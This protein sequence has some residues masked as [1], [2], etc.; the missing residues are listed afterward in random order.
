VQGKIAMTIPFGTKAETLERLAPLLTTAC[1]LPQYRFRHRDWSRQR[2]L[3]LAGL[4]SGGWLDRPVI[5]RSSALQ[6][7][8]GSGSLAGQLVSVADVQGEGAV[9]AAVDRVFSSYGV[10]AEDDQV[11]LQPLLS[12]PS[13]SGVAFGLE[14]NT[15]GPYLVINYDEGAQAGA[16][17]GGFSDADRTFYWFKGAA[18]PSSPPLAAVARL[19]RELEWLLGDEALDVEFAWKDEKLYLFQIRRLATLKGFGASRAEVAGLLQVV[20]NQVGRQAGERPRVL[21]SGVAWGIMPDWNPAEMIGIRPR[22]LAASLYRECLTDETWAR[23]RKRYAYRDLRGVPL[24]ECLGGQPFIDIRASFTSFVPTSLP[25]GLAEKLV[26]YYLEGLRSR[27]EL[28]DKVETELVLHCYTFDLPERLRDLAGAGFHEGERGQLTA[29]LRELTV[30]VMDAERGPWA[31]DRRKIDRFATWLDRHCSPES[32][33]AGDLLAFLRTCTERAAAPF[34]GLARAGFMATCLLRSL[35]RIGLWTPEEEERFLRGRRTVVSRMRE[36]RRHL[37]AAAFLSRYGHLRP[38]TYDILTPRYDEAPERYFL[39][40]SVEEAEEHA[41]FCLTLGQRGDL[42]ALLAAHKL[43][44]DPDAFLRFVGEAIE[45]R[46]YG[47]FVYSRGVSEWLRRFG[48]YAARWGFSLDDCSYATVAVLRGVSAGAER[49]AALARAVA[50]GRAAY[51]AT[52]GLSLPPLLL[53]VEDV[54]SFHQPRFLPNYVTRGVAVGPVRGIESPRSD[55]T[56][57]VLFLPCADPGYD[58]IFTTGIAAFVTMFGG[59]NSHMAIRAR[60]WNLPAAIGVGEPCFRCLS[61][62]RAVRV[63]CL[64]KQL[65]IVP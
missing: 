15:E 7:D 10:P 61:K 19:M 40:N 13:L 60:E 17:T 3:V 34:A 55:L 38:G 50:A 36:D 48:A 52:M 43:P 44:S 53:S 24:L 59:A 63:D 26:E 20:S 33:E 12:S 42:A 65:V 64:H 4:R 58:W 25:D 5:V 57:G 32:V 6:E 46:E 54:R 30:R 49:G 51:R 35:V 62:A 21:G 37:S 1:V 8:A 29:A 16:V 45:T 28:H 9:V 22:P 14:P 23:A 41:P 31:E 18:L 56:G 47:K 27:P 39:N 2:S 11:F